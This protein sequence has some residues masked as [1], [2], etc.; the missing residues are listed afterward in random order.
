MSGRKKKMLFAAIFAALLVAY[1]CCLPRR[2]FDRPCATVVTDSNGQ[3]LGAR[4]A[5]DGQWRFPHSDSVPE[6]FRICVVE[7]ED[8]RF[9]LHPGID[10]LAMIRAT[11]HNIRQKRIVSGGS[12]ITMQ[13]V[14]LSRNR[15]RTF[16]EKLCETLLATRL[17]LRCSKSEILA[18]YASNAP[19]GGNVVGLEAAAWRY[20]GRPADRLSW[21]ETATLAVLPNAPSL[22]NLSR[23]RQAL[24]NK[25]NRLLEKLLAHGHID[26]STFDLAL[27]EPLPDR[28]LPL[29]DSA[30]HLV[31]WCAHNHAETSCR[32]T[33]DGDLQHNV[34][35]LLA[36]HNSEFARQG[37]RHLAAMVVEVPTAKVVAW[38]G[39]VGF[40]EAGE[41]NQ[42]DVLLSQRSTGSILKPFLLCAMLQEGEILSRTLQ[43]DIPLNIN[44]F[45]PQNFNRGYEGAIAAEEAVSRS[46]NVPLVAMLR[47]Y[48]VPKFYNFLKQN[49]VADLPQPSEH[50]GLSLILGGAEASPADVVM[51][52]ANMARSLHGLGG[53]RYSLLID[54]EA[55]DLPVTFDPAAV[56]QVFEA[57]TEVNRPEQIDW[58]A[59]PSMRR[60]AWKTGTSFGARDAWAAGVTPS[61]AV[62]VWAG[63]ASG[64]GR[65]DLSGARTA[66]PVMFDIFELLPQ[67]SWFKQ[68]A[69]QL[70]EAEVCSRSGMLKSRHCEMYDTALICPAGLRSQPCTFCIPVNLTADRRFRVHQTCAEAG[71]I[72]QSSW[73]VLPPA[74]AWYYRR[75]HP[76]YQPPP[77]FSNTCASS[78]EIPM[79]FIYPQSD[80]KISLP[81]QMDGSRSPVTFELAHN[82]PN[83]T[84]YWHI[85][86]DY[87]ASTADFHKLTVNLTEGRH[88]L[89]AVDDEGNSISCVVEVVN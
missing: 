9:Y 42:V 65:P 71:E 53:K 79:Q 29:P 18:L 26:R 19:F 13:V 77:P 39:N 81:R 64:E 55:Q 70:V 88:N 33:I 84:V 85:D 63:N 82:R 22:I 44:G 21:A 46:L 8:R 57:L 47:R 31:E 68:P 66:G 37:I 86:N 38:C 34:E 75:Q 4:I 30:P 32:T 61:H 6:K 20:F 49:H 2:L 16:A 56:R 50:Y 40:N 35:N 51:A 24:L 43:P 74:W 12:T 10:P 89:T 3:L 87:I 60:V 36:R 5:S 14:R 11:V 27:A 83:A 67:T 1:Y 23:N 59:M 17:E 76:D 7:F 25:R 80:V 54:E 73:F 41:G 48:S 62:I 78:T 15:S 72:I 58:R 69:G 52:Y 45:A 28:A